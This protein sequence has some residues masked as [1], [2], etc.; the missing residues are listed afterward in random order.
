MNQNLSEKLPRK[1][2]LIDNHELCLYGI[3]NIL[4]STY[5]NVEIITAKTAENAL[6]QISTFKPDLL[7]MDIY[8][9]HQSGRNANVETG[10]QMLKQIVQHYPQL[11]IV[12]QSAHIKT[13]VRMKYE[14]DSHCGGF[15]VVDKSETVEEML[16][17]IRWALQGITHIKDI[18]CINFGLQEKPEWS[19]LLSLAYQEGLQDKAIAQHISVSERMVRHYWFNLQEAL[20][21]D[22]EQLKHQGKNLR[23]ITRNRATEVGLID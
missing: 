10:M 1:I 11:N 14:I 21:I 3:F 7:I 4:S 19:R 2:L 18:P 16:T 23:I 9:S 8:I 17:R 22:S 15:T 13:L 20:G 12:I 6:N 5:P